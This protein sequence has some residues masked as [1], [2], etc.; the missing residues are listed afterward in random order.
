MIKLSGGYAGFPII[1]GALHVIG[2]ATLRNDGDQA[3]RISRAVE[4]HLVLM[5]SE[6]ISSADRTNITDA[7]LG[8][9]E[10]L[11]LPF[12]VS[13]E[14]EGM[15][16]G[17]PVNV[18]VRIGVR[19]IWTDEAGSEND[20][21]LWAEASGSASETSGEPDYDEDPED[22]EFVDLSAAVKKYGV[23]YDI[24]A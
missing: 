20:S 9:G 7:V 1:N 18:K 6:P 5:G 21:L 8:P 14:T 17:E 16:A 3:V 4:R 24:P 12:S 23:M 15:A 13:P 10:E 19:V 2:S 11:H 22:N